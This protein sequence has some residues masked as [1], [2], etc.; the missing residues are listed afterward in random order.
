MSGEK[1]DVY[2]A[3]CKAQNGK[4]HIRKSQ[5]ATKACHGLFPKRLVMEA[6]CLFAQR[7]QVADYCRQQ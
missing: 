2:S 1:N 3:D 7:L 5:N 6:A 4:F